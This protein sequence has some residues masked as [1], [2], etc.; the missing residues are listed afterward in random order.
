MNLTEFSDTTKKPGEVMPRDLIIFGYPGSG[1]STIANRVVELTRGLYKHVDVLNYLTIIKGRP[2]PEE[3]MERAYTKVYQEME[4]STQ[5]LIIELSGRPEQSINR[6]VEIRR[7]REPILVYLSCSK[8]KCL[9]DYARR[10][11]AI[12]EGD[13]DRKIA[14]YTQE[15]IGK[16]ARGAGVPFHVIN[17]ENLIKKDKLE[18]D[19]AELDSISRSLLDLGLANVT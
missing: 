1:K 3:E 13:L 6:T 15:R 12:P 16:I 5:P 7:N 19:E 2:I 8:E 17:T 18:I 4:S 9:R 14:E 10:G 11:R